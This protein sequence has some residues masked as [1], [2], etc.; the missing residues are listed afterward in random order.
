MK[1]LI[2]FFLISFC[3]SNDQIPGLD[4]KRPILLRGGILH[5]VSGGILEGHD[6]LFANGKIVSIGENIQPSPDTDVYDIF[7]KL[8]IHIS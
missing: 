5:T 3:L 1:K 6:L 8:L 2:F 7:E 4:Q